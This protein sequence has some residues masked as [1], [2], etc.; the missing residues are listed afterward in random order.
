MSVELKTIKV[1]Q[2][3]SYLHFTKIE[4]TPTSWVTLLNVIKNFKYLKN[5]KRLNN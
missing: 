1:Q 4:H 5:S 2:N 3:L